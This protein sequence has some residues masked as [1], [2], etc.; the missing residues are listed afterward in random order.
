M[1]RL[2][3]PGSYLGMMSVMG[4]QIHQFSASAVEASDICLSIS[5][6]QEHN[7]DNGNM[8]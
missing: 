3:L 2:A 8:R 5:I 7:Y 1:L 6:L 4:D